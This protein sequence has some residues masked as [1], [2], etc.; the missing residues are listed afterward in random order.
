MKLIIIALL[1]LLLWFKPFGKTFS[2]RFSFKTVEANQNLNKKLTKKIRKLEDTISK[3]QFQSKKAK[4]GGGEDLEPVKGL[5]MGKLSMD[6]FNWQK[7]NKSP[8]DIN[9]ILGD[10]IKKTVQEERGEKVREKTDKKEKKLALEEEQVK[11]A[12]QYNY[13]GFPVFTKPEFPQKPGAIYQYPKGMKAGKPPQQKN[14]LSHLNDIK[15]KPF[16]TEKY[17]QKA[18]IGIEK[19]H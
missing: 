10:L 2:K 14:E 16:N 12:R 18:D 13:D 5:D 9:L 17:N 3:L 8:V 7:L 11:K 19:A 4:L 15:P 1:L 6:L